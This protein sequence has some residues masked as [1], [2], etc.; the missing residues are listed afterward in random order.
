MPDLIPASD[1]IRG[2][3][4]ICGLAFFATNESGSARIAL[5]TENFEVLRAGMS[6]ALEEITMAGDFPFLRRVEQRRYRL[7]WDSG[8]TYAA[9]DE[10]FHIRSGVYV[11]AL[12]ASTGQEPYDAAGTLNSA[13]WQPCGK[14]YS[15]ADWTDTTV[16]ATVGT[17]YRYPVNG[18]Y[19]AL[20]TAAPTGTVPTN[21]SYFGVLTPFD[22]YVPYELTGY[23]TIDTC[24]EVTNANPNVTSALVR[25]KHFASRNGIQVIA[26]P[27]PTEPWLTYKMRPARLRGIPFDATATYAATEQVFY[28]TVANGVVTGDFY[29]VVTATS[30]GQT[31]DSHPA[32]FT[33]VEIPR[34]L[35]LFLKHAAAA[36]WFRD[37]GN[38]GAE[39]AAALASAN[40][41]AQQ[42]YD[43]L[44]LEDE[45]QTRIAR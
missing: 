9:G 43:R 14:S 11:Q 7:A 24:W 42:L 36:A 25:Y 23:N 17:I 21:T 2:A 37:Q 16:L 45:R 29:D 40:Q 8:T 3:C 6:D 15:G 32:K 20:H 26:D 18:L 5:T 10:R 28:Y 1:V 31:P 35:N 30:A 22:P 44:A 34:H 33:K 41:F 27:L 12:R 4:A 39:A 38:R 13:Y 19:Y